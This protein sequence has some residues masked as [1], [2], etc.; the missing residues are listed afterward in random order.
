MELISNPLRKVDL[1][2]S[3]VF[4]NKFEMIAKKSKK[5][6]K[7]GEA[8]SSDWAL[9]NTKMKQSSSS[10]AS[11]R[12]WYTGENLRPP[13]NLVFDGYISYDQDNFGG[14][15]VYCPLWYTHLDWFGIPEFNYRVGLEVE[16]SVLSLPRDLKVKKEKLACIF[17]SNPH[18]LR[19]KI[20][21]E[22]SKFGQ[23]DVFGLRKSTQVKY[24]H[25]V[26]REY[27]YSICFENDLYP[28]Y[29]TEKLLDAYLSETVPL[30][31]GDLGFDDTINDQSFFNLAKFES[32]ANFIEM[33]LT[34][35]YESIYCQ[36][37]LV[38]SPQ[39]TDLKNLLLGKVS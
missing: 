17:L 29:V 9:M 33:A 19:L 15:N 1:E 6:V 12:I 28:G 2:I 8:D 32:M 38:K 13:L 30:Y 24:K 3:S 36:P 22:L 11:R 25:D 34:T 10:F 31:W 23:V 14:A 7:F 35:D 27:K 20:I 37:L 39:I 26:A 4:L 18:P 5:L 21:Q 16:R